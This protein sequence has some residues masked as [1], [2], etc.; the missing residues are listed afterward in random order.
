MLRRVTLLQLNDCYSELMAYTVLAYSYWASFHDKYICLHH[1][2]YRYRLQMPYKRHRT[3][4]TNRMRS[5][6]HHITPLVINS[7]GGR[8]TNTHTRKHTCIQTFTDRSNSKK[9]GARRLRPARAWFKK[10]QSHR[11]NDLSGRHD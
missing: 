11:I 6:L 1:A 7:L 4:S 10:F 8:H 3:Y 9:P 5:I 2:H